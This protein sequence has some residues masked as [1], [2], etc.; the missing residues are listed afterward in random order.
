MEMRE[1][2]TDEGY[3]LAPFLLR[4]ASSA[5]DLALAVAGLMLL[6]LFVFPNSSFATLS[7]ALGVETEQTQ[8]AAYQKASGLVSSKEDG[9]LTNVTSSS[10][11]DYESAIKTYY[12]VYNAADNQVNPH[13]EAYSISDYNVAVLDLPQDV[14]NTNASAYYDFAMSNEQADPSKLGVLKS[15][16]YD[17]SGNLTTTAKSQLLSFFQNKYKLTQDLLLKEDYYKSLT[18]SL[19]N[20]V[21]TMET[22]VFFPPFLIFYFVIPT[23]SPYSRTLGKK[24]MKLAVIDVEGTPLKKGWLILR[25][26]PLALTAGISILFDDLVISTTLSLVVF[27][28]SMG[29]GSFT[30]KRRCLH[31]YC[32]HSVV[33]RE[34]DAFP[35]EAEASHAQD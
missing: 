33:V 14:K 24:W 31:D 34:E 27:L 4:V 30:K 1:E 15:S 6:Y 17:A 20:N 25:F 19:A 35:K 18:T 28:V 2:V 13:P 16:L 11:E 21:E 5:I 29:L 12:F 3:R 7:T 10:Y 9:T 32:A 23:F 26:M 22:I 8:I